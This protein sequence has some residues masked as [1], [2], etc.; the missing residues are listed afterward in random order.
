VARKIRLTFTAERVSAIAE[1]LEE[2][3]PSTC[4]A[5]WNALPV[6]GESHHAIYSGSEVVLILPEMVRVEPEN[7][8]AYVSTGDVGYTYFL[9]GS[10]ATVETQFSEICWFYHWDAR[11]SMW[12]GPAP[13]SIF[14]RITDGADP[15][16]AVCRRMRREGVKPLAI[17]RVEESNDDG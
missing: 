17:E 3:A 7:A 10:S 15:F 16:Y 11:P 9:P 6:H 13:V 4:E 14:A 5:I 2:E 12:E 1:M 8:T